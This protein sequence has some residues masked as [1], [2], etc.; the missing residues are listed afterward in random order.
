MANTHSLF[1]IRRIY[2]RGKLASCNYA[3]SYCP[4]G[5]KSHSPV[6]LE[7]DKQ[8]W[9]RFITAIGHWKGEPLQL[10]IIPYGEALIHEYYREGIHRLAMLPQV[11]GVSCQTNLFFP[12]EQWLDELSSSPAA[13][14]KIK[15]WASF[16][17]EMTTVNKFVRQLHSLYHAGMQVCAGAVGNPSAKP[18]LSELRD[19]LTPDIYLFI[20]AMQGLKTPLSEE[21][22]QF[23]SLLD[24]LFEY[25]RKNAPAQWDAC[26]GG[27]SSCFVDWKGDIYA[28]PRSRVRI[29]NFY[30][31]E[32][33][34]ISLSC[35]RKVCDCYIA[36]SNLNHHPLHRMMGN[37]TFWRIPG[38]PLIRSAFFDID[39]TLTNEQGTVPESYK[40][41][42]QYMAQ[43]IPLYL[44]TSLSVEQARRKLGKSLF[45]LF[46]GGVFAGGGLLSYAGQV[47][48]LQVDALP[49]ICKEAS[50]T[51]A[52]S[53]YGQIYKYSLLVVERKVRENIWRELE[54]CS[55][56][57]LYRKGPLITVIHRDA[58]KKEGVRRICTA[59]QLPL[60]ET[61]VVGNSFEDK[62]MM[63][64]VPH[65]CA[66]LNAHPLLKECAR[67]VLNPDRLPAFFQMKT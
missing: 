34:D 42:L 48:C 14:N 5:R 2:Y 1:S 4:F 45:N 16:H 60:E 39:G 27:R 28:C 63:S 40:S 53:C 64:L 3:C 46:Q 29:G 43:K 67:Y 66:V 62:E 10:F 31:S 52:Y 11:M 33:L 54:K 59:L 30:G 65:S 49:D 21:D 61:I 55:S 18:L 58:G 23:F 41:S 20:N 9:Q 35:K 36:F 22:I 51:T 32:E 8:A 25:D 19:K 57:R 7:E 24:N 50:K 44:A 56:Y 17:P 6:F 37:G 12:A 47:E 13:V 15:V 38:K 26:A